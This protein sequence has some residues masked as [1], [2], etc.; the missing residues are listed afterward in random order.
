MGTNEFKNKFLEECL[1]KPNAQAM[2]HTYFL[3]PA[4]YEYYIKIGIIKNSKIGNANV[5]II[6]ALDEQFFPKLF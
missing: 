4:Q 2:V 1:M 3:T 5:E 6:I